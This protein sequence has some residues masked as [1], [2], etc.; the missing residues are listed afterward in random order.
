[1]PPRQPAQS[2]DDA[3]DDSLA[4]ELALS[5]GEPAPAAPVPS[6]TLD[7]EMSRLLGELSNAKR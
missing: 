5:L 1:V 3:L 7:D 6:P 2:A 4:S